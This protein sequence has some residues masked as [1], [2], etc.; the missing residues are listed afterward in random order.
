MVAASVARD[1]SRADS[2]A[3]N[4]VG[5]ATTVAVARRQ[6]PPMALTGEL[7]FVFLAGLVVG[8]LAMLPMPLF[9]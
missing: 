6:P 4:A 8:A 9:L 2:G 3:P 7:V 5:F 1:F